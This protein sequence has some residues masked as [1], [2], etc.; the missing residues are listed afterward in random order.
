MFF[1][2]V[3]ICSF[4]HIFVHDVFVIFVLIGSVMDFYKTFFSGASWGTAELFLACGS[5]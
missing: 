5:M 4:L 3:I 1:L 2:L